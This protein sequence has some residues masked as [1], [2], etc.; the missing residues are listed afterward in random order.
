MNLRLSH[1]Y[2]LVLASALLLLWC[3]GFGWWQS[4]EG[5]VGGPMSLAKVLWLFLA[6]LHFYLIP[7]WLWRDRSLSAAARKLWGWFFAGFVLRALV[8]IPLL[9][10]TRL[11]RCEHGIAHDAVMLLLLLVMTRRL[12]PESSRVESSFAWLAA[13]AL[14][15]EA[16]NAWLF[17]HC[18]SPAEGIYFASD[19]ARFRLINTITW[20]EIIVLFPLVLCWW[21]SY[22]RAVR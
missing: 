8:E 4:G 20:A 2:R 10:G 7:A 14:V 13:L 22:S 18:G 6:L 15:F 16:T 11:W 21:R 3:L 1:P 12:P 9:I 19:E 17:R 5:R